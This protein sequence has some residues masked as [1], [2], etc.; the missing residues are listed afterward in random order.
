MKRTITTADEIE[1]TKLLMTYSPN[2]AAIIDGICKSFQLT[3]DFIREFRQYITKEAFTLSPY[4]SVKMAEKYPEYFDEELFKKALKKNPS[5]DFSISMVAKYISE[6]PDEWD[7][8]DEDSEKDY[9]TKESY[10]EDLIRNATTEEL[11]EDVVPV[12]LGL[13]SVIDDLILK[14]IKNNECLVQSILLSLSLNDSQPFTSSTYK[15][16]PNDMKENLI[17]TEDVDARN[18]INAISDSDDFGWKL[19][20]LHDVE[21]G[22][23]NILETG[24]TM[25]NEMLHLINKLPETEI[26]AFTKLSNK[27]KNAFSGKIMMWLLKN[28]SFSEEELIEMFPVFKKAGLYFEIKKLAREENYEKLKE[29]L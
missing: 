29:L 23:I 21:N 9:E 14:R 4:L 6:V 25:D 28:K 11:T 20:M 17:G 2:P 16:M 10:F 22:K 18:F 19:K 3:D 24:A 5:T 12:F 26:V 1:A 15:Y 8:D 7:S 27:L 13:N